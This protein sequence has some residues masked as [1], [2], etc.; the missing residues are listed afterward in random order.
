MANA[1]IITPETL[2]EL[3]DY[4]PLT[5]ELTWKRRD[6]SY[7]ANRQSWKRWN[8]RFAGEPAM[9]AF[10]RGYRKGGVNSV[11]LSAHRVAWAI[12]YGKWPSMQIDH[13]NGIRTDNRIENLR[14]VS[15]RENGLNT[16]L[17]SANTS[18]VMG[19]TWCKARQKWQA[20]IACIMIGRFE[21]FE[22]AVA[23]RKAAERE[24]G[25]HPNH[26]RP[27]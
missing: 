13:I 20:Q 2:R 27:Q 22:E 24:Q 26:G 12:H 18:G 25:Y 14:D 3:I 6:V 17:N 11:Q 5:G 8:N 1:P 7:F 21:T 10:D 23:A 16:K 19:V 9:R 4:D 15:Q